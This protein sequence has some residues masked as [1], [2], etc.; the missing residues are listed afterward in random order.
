M[1]FR[2]VRLPDRSARMQARK[3]NEMSKRILLPAFAVLLAAGGCSERNDL[4]AARE[5]VTQTKFP[6]MVTSGGD[7]SGQVLARAKSS[8]VSSSGEAA[9]TPGIP[10]GSGGNTSGAALGG[11]TPGASATKPD[12][13]GQGDRSPGVPAGAGR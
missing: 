8:E 4:E 5:E 10:E 11:T 1:V 7:T 6:G 3:E 2:R 13:T 9:G 12:T